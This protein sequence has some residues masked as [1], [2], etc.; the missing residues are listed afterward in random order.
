[1]SKGYMRLYWATNSLDAE[2]PDYLTKAIHYGAED[3]EALKKFVTDTYRK[4]HLKDVPVESKALLKTHRFVRLIANIKS[5]LDLLDNGYALPVRDPRRMYTPKKN[6]VLYLLH[7]SLPINSGGYATRTHG[8]LTGLARAKFKVKGVTRL[9]FPQ[10]RGKKYNAQTYPDFDIIEGV[11]YLRLQ[12]DVYGLGRLPMRDYIDH[13]IH[14]HRALIETHKPAI[15]H[16]ASNFINGVTA[17]ALARLYGLISIYEVRGLWEITRMSREPEYEGTDAFNLYV[18]METEA[19]RNADHCFAITGALKNEMV[20]RGVDADKITIIPNGVDTSRFN[21][22]NKDEDLKAELGFAPDDL[23]VG[24]IGSIVD[25]EGLD[26]LMMA[27]SLIKKQGHK[28][29]KALIVGDGDR[30]DEIKALSQKLKLND[31]VL[32]TGRIPHD[33]VE[34]HYSIVDIAPFPRKGMPVCEMV[35]PLKPFE[36]MAMGKPV[37]ISNV[38]AMKEFVI[39]GQTGIIIEKDNPQSLSE[40]ILRLALDESLRISTANQALKFVR[41]ERDWR[42]IS[43]KIA[44]VYR[45]LLSQ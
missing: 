22:M 6:T 34:R 16:G 25:Y 20:R 29:I 42:V 4:G 19:C 41:E 17:T 9:G 28:H 2:M 27:L 24:Y 36:A 7:N 5:S 11:D 21:P 13:N 39:D 32:F 18:R 14:A 37:I 1:M 12:S 40:G 38:A 35:S 15:I 31:L 23:I 44:A 43:E 3:T 10:D 8:I 26:Y 33:D 45:R 30:L